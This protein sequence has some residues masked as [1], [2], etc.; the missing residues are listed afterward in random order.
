MYPS[1]ESLRDTTA[2]LRPTKVS[3]GLENH[4]AVLTVDGSVRSNPQQ[5][6]HGILDQTEAD[7]FGLEE[8]LNILT[9]HWSSHEPWRDEVD[10]DV[11]CPDRPTEVAH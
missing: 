7:L 8:V 1:G 11:L 10:S 9:E 6:L 4:M 3:K 2:K 5:A